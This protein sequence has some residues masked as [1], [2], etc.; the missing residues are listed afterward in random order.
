MKKLSS[1]KEYLSNNIMMLSIGFKHSPNKLIVEFI[2]K[3]FVMFESFYILLL[4]DFLLTSLE[5]D[6]GVVYIF[7]VMSICAFIWL[8]VKLFINYYNERVK[9]IFSVG[10]IQDINLRLFDKAKKIDLNCY[11]NPEFYDKYTNVTKDASKRII[12]IIDNISGIS[13]GLVI[14]VFYLIK[15]VQVDYITIFVVIL[16]LIATIFF[17]KKLNKAEYALYIENI[18]NIRKKEYVKRVVYYEQYSK[19]LR[20]FDIYNVLKEIF[21]ES[22]DDSVKVINK[23]VNKMVFLR[24]LQRLCAG[25]IPTIIFLMYKTIQYINNP[26]GL[27]DFTVIFYGVLSFSSALELLLAKFVKMETDSLYTNNLRIFLDYE[28]KI[29]SPEKPV[30]VPKTIESIELKNLSF[31]YPGTEKM[32]LKNIN[33]KISKKNKV[34]IV[35]YN[36]AGKTTI[37]KLILRLYDPTNGEVLL[38]GVNI[39]KYDLDEYRQLISSVLQDFNMYSLPITE[40]ILM[41]EYK[42]SHDKK[43]RDSLEST[44]MLD[45]IDSFKKGIHSTLTKE[46]DQEG[47]VL[48]LGKY[49]RLAI[50]RA[51]AMN[52][53][54]LLLDEPSSAL[55]PIAEDLM[56]KSMIELSDNKL[57]V[58]V[59]HMLSS[60][61]YADTIYVIE[62]GQVKEEGNHKKLMENKNLYYNLYTAQSK[63]YTD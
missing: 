22:T 57:V 19:E 12:D 9:P 24:L 16:P 18:P 38:N 55:D 50:S 49:Q 10:L 54:V 56:W 36:G 34:S 3:F 53:Q 35:G 1:L 8:F 61:K 20:L 40:N 45:E 63:H 58:F 21:T 13:A 62:N 41:D 17:G 46:F 25:S 52:K 28:E 5:E 60:S 30:A 14:S 32:I 6:K 51:F 27:G 26:F 7:T 31:K 37:I 42:N 59:S 15:L 11:E 33:I 48:S 43:I 2:V 47:K 39:K 4:I 44:K 23:Y 29:V